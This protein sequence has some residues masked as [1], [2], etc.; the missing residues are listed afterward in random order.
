MD[1]VAGF[2]MDSGVD[3]GEALEAAPK[4]VACGLD[5]AGAIK[6][7]DPQRLRRA[8]GFSDESILQLLSHRSAADVQASLA[9]NRT[10]TY[11]IDVD[12]VPLSRR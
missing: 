12:D 2:L 7:S 8:S 9:G 3:F 10:S 6:A 1:A 4:L 5:S 11:S